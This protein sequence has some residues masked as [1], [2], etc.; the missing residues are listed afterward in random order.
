[1]A[2]GLADIAGLVSPEQLT[3]ILAVAVPPTLQLILLPGQILPLSTPPPPPKTSTTLTGRQELI[4]HCKSKI[5]PDPSAAAF[6]TCEAR[7]PT[8]VLAAAIFSTLER[9]FFDST[10]AHAE[11]ASNFFYYCSSTT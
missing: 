3:L 6:E 10:T 11:L 1:M 9:H 8:R 5:L 7:T 4:K 2:K